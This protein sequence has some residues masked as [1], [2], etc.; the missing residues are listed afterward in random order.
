MKGF[1][2]WVLKLF[3]TSDEVSSKR[4]GGIFLIINGV[5]L[6]YLKGNPQNVATLII[7]GCALLGV[8]AFAERLGGGHNI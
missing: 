6:A 3:S 7:S 5:V 8:G 4:I 2:N 1:I